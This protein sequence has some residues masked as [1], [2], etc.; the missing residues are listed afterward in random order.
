MR[1]GKFVPGVE[2]AAFERELT[3]YL[4]VVHGI[5]VGSGTDALTIGLRAIGVGPGDEVITSPFGFFAT[6]EAI[7][8]IGAVPVFVDIES[9]TLN[10]DPR[11]AARAVTSR[12]KSI[13]PVH[14]F[15]HPADMS[16]ISALADERGLMMLED[17]AQALGACEPS[18]RLHRSIPSSS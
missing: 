4:G 13:L 16:A 3:D 6:A 17:A 8:A 12:P 11:L 9:D 7:S 18:L 2:V 1:S 5:G 15:G 14:I 10:L